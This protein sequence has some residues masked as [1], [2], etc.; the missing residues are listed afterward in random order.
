MQENIF[1]SSL[2]KLTSSTWRGGKETN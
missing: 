1:R 2:W